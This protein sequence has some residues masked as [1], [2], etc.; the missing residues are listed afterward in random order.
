MIP[1]MMLER[2]SSQETSARITGES[3]LSKVLT[4]FQINFPRRQ[5]KVSIARSLI[6][7]PSIIIAD[8]PTANLDSNAAKDVMEIFRS[9]NRE[10]HTIIMVTHE[11]EEVRYGNRAIKLSDGVLV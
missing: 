7:N 5:Q 6:N 10:G 9:L 8:E 4:I 3:R 1:A 2:Q 11:S